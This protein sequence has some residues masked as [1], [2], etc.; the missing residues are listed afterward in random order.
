ML[1]PV[2]TKVLDI[3]LQVSSKHVLSSGSKEF[4]VEPPPGSAELREDLELIYV[5]LSLS[6]LHN[7]LQFLE[8]ESIF[9][10]SLADI[11]DQGGS[12]S[13]GDILLMS[14]ECALDDRVTL[15]HLVIK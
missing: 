13:Q 14:D 7:V 3:I 15:D 5:D 6:S 8:A 10:C 12:P 11:Y 9:L 2:V 1:W 4:I